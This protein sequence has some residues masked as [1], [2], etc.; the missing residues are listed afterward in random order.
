MTHVHNTAK[1]NTC[2]PQAP[3]Q[4]GSRYEGHENKP[5]ECLPC[6][7]N[8]YQDATDHREATCKPHVRCGPGTRL[9]G[10]SEAAAGACEACPAGQFRSD[11]EHYEGV[12]T[13]HKQ[14]PPTQ[15]ALATGTAATDTTC[16]VNRACTASEYEAAPQTAGRDGRVCEALASCEAGRFVKA[17]HTRTTDR[18]CGY[19]DGETYYADE[20]NLPACKEFSFCS[21]GEFV[22]TP[23]TATSDLVCGACNSTKDE[24]QGLVNGSDDH[25]A[26][27]CRVKQRCPQGAFAARDDN[28]RGRVCEA[29]P[30]GKHMAESDHARD[31][32]LPHA[33]CPAG[34]QLTNASRSRAGACQACAGGQ[35]RPTTAEPRCGPQALCHRDTFAASPGSTS[36][37]RVCE[38][39]PAGKFVAK[40]NHT[41]ARC[42]A[43]A[44]STAGARGSDSSSTAALAANANAN[45][46]ATTT[47]ATAT[48]TAAA[49]T[50]GGVATATTAAAAATAHNATRAAGANAGGGG[51]GGSSGG[52]TATVIAVVVILSLVLIA[53]L[54]IFV[55]Q[56]RR[57]GPS[58]TAAT[59][60]PASG[61]G[62]GHAAQRPEDASGVSVVVGEAAKRGGAAGG[63]PDLDPNAFE[64]A[65]T[66]AATQASVV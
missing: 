24:Y 14:C 20:P 1:D 53:A 65:N 2:V 30:E 28:I 10:T 44:S 64:F 39:C 15:K 62:R 54:A 29:C 61:V 59:R 52:F 37:D 6:P 8:R 9:G 26:T 66:G 63:A 18:V 23:G 13:P 16:T 40:G 36:T 33:A 45:A 3:C 31:T 49:D 27:A 17:A 19:C 12:C 57:R 22:A 41:D 51:G 32:C 48:A 60:P 58:R 5:R 35:F 56:E 34:E 47:A 42:A 4:A 43:P 21:F 38:A 55:E 25:R 7:A 50:R 46:N 11:R